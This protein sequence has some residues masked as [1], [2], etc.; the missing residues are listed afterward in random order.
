VETNSLEILPF[1]VHVPQE[2]LDD[3]R[4]RLERV[5]WA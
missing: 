3:L 2:L 4:T 1:R 5:R